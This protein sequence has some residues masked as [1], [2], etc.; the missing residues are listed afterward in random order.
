MKK[1]LFAFSLLITGASQLSAQI[2]YSEDFDNI[3]GP[4]AGGVGTYVMAPGMLLRNVDNRTPDAQVSY[5]NEAW[6]RRED[7][8]QNVVDSCAF[9]N[10]Y[11]SPVGAANDFMWTPVIG[12]ITANTELSWNAKTYD[13]S[14][15]ESYEVRIMT[16]APTGGTGVIGNQLTSSTVIF[17]TAAEPASWTSHVVSLAAYSGQSVYIGFRNVS[18][19]KFLLVVDDILVQVLLMYDAQ[20]LSADATEYTSEPVSQRTPNI[21]SGVVRNNGL[22]A[23]T[24]VQLQLTVFDGAMTQIYTN[25]SP[26]LST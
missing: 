1:I 24:N 8:G 20:L 11:Y 17:S 21:I 22:N 6:E 13:P 12:P 19:D 26:V 2:L 18:N 15:P 14:Y 3:P 25:S 10:S 9:S 23:L 4:T 16:V 5:V 7:F